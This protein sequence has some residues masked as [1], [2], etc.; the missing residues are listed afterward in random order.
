MRAGHGAAAPCPARM[1]LRAPAARLACSGTPADKEKNMT[2]DGFREGERAVQRRA[3]VEHQ[4]ARLEGMLD[5]PGLGEGF[6]RFL[7]ERDFAV[8]TGRDRAGRLWASPLTGRPGMLDACGTKLCVAVAPADGDP[9]V[10]LPAG[11][12]VG[13]LAIEFAT[14][15]RVRVNGTLT[16]ADGLVLE[17]AVAQA[18]GNCPQYIQ[19]RQLRPAAAATADGPARTAGT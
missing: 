4:A 9:L 15:R 13:L 14:R 10:G 7:A 17:I 11:Q 1:T 6:R 16:A 8:L 5:R 12:P 18:Y 2:P 19:Q 3:G